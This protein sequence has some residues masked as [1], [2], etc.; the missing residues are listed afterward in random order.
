MSN[1]SSPTDVLGCIPRFYLLSHLFDTNSS[2]CSSLN[3]SKISSLQEL[4][5]LPYLDEIFVED[6]TTTC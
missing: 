4:D 2:D 5:E 6:S 1:F 3:G